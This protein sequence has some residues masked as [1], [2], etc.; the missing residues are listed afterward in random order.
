MGGALAH[1]PDAEA[2]ALL[3]ALEEAGLPGLEVEYRLSRPVLERLLPELAPRGLK[4]VSLHSPV[5][6][7]PGVP[8]QAANADIFSLAS[9][10]AE[11]RRRGVDCALAA[12]EL[13]SDL[14][15]KAV[16]LHLGNVEA[17]ADKQVT[18]AA[19]QD[20]GLSNELH[21]MLAER[22]GLA[23]RH[24]DAVSFSLERLAG[25]AAPLGVRLGLENR[26]HAFQIPDFAEL[27]LLLDRF[28]GAPLG[29][30]YDCGHAWVQELA[31]LTPA[32]D[33][34]AAYGQGLV[35]C[36][37]HDA[38]QAQDHQAPGL[39][40]M[41]WP[42]LT[43]ALAAAP[44]KVLEVPGGEMADLRRGAAMLAGLFADAERAR[45]KEAQR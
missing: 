21:T 19:A 35:G 9:L 11:V 34:L 14:E 25:R 20:G 1:D 42:A 10:D 5:P 44:V 12:L 32:A 39:G 36:H 16:V 8:R 15:V 41:D 22:A 38:V 23:P 37:L 29:L 24:L 30:W 2:A 43:R 4:V 18:P 40:E 6:L 31:G 27:G 3:A 17:L 45:E 26:Y 7:P 13:A 28:Q 33:W